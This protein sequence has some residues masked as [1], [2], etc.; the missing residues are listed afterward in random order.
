MLDSDT[1]NESLANA[2]AVLKDLE[3]KPNEAAEELRPVSGHNSSILLPC[4]GADG[5]PYLLKYFVPP[6]ESRFYPAGVRVEDYARREGAFYRFLDS[7]DPGRILLPAP[8]TIL[9]DAV[10]PP[11]WILLE[12]ISPA[13]G[14]AEE[15]FSMDHVFELIAKLQAFSLEMFFGRRDFP[16]NHW[17]VVSYLERVRLMYDPVLGVIGDK[18]WRRSIEFFEDAMRWIETQAP[19]LVH[20]DFTEENILVDE[21]GRPFL[22]DFERIGFG[23]EFHDLAWLWIHSERPQSWKKSLM[24]RFFASRMGSE[25]VKAE[26]GIR[27]ALVYLAM[28]R[29]RFGALVHGQEDEAAPRNVALLDAAL[30]GGLD[31]F[32]A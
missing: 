10:D 24:Q 15:V 3:L 11:R 29:L 13:V 25:R 32:P 5:R 1:S 27:S 19:T 2:R 16:L 17:S 22:L 20:G 26:W 30:V 8:R 7:T 21:E 6:S 9:I 14:P 12:W 23:N 4:A 31:L 28:R 18:R